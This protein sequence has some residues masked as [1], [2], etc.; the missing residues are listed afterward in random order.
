M[1]NCTS[2]YYPCSETST[3]VEVGVREESMRLGNIG[4]HDTSS[5]GSQVVG[6]EC[7]P[8][9]EITMELKSTSQQGDHHHNGCTFESHLHHQVWDHG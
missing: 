1:I 5:F 7:I 4:S 9:F 6:L 3:R 8:P 2:I